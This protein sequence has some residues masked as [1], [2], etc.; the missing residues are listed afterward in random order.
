MAEEDVRTFD[1]DVLACVRFDPHARSKAFRTRTQGHKIVVGR[2]GCKIRRFAGTCVLRMATKTASKTR[3]AKT[4]ATEASALAVPRSRRLTGD[5]D[6]RF[7][8]V[9]ALIE[10]ARGRAYQAVNAELVSLYWQ[11][12]EYISRKIASAEWGDGVVEELA[13]SL[14]RRFPGLRGFTRP[15]LF[16]MRQ[17]YEAY[18]SNRKVSALLRQ[19]PWTHHLLILGQAKPTEAREFYILAAIKERWSSRELERQLRSGAVLRDAHAAKKV[20]PAL[21]Q[22]PDALSE[23]KNAYNLEFLA[24][25][26]GHSEADLHSS[27]LQHLGRFLTELGRDFCFVGSKY[28]VQVGKQDFEIDLVFFHRGLQCLVAFE[29][30]VDKFKPADLGQ[31]SFYV[32]ALDRDVKK[33]HERPSIGVLLCATKDDEVVEYALARTT[34]PTLVAEY[35]TFLPPKEVLRAK[36]HELYALLSKPDDHHESR[37]PRIKGGRA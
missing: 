9:I 14:A 7:A 5:E 31:L 35:Q 36:L 13:A 19:L 26:D 37:T 34:S 3:A 33:P 24:L 32:E 21:R 2:S 23:L 17:F 16:R 10:A 1:F 11:L 8:E 4:V 27:L 20:S 15:N 18:R 22:I 25:A 12:G 29:L 28:P 30:K 6:T